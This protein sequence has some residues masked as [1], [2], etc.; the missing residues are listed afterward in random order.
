MRRGGSFEGSPERNQ[1]GVVQ[2][3]GWEALSEG[4]CC[5]CGTSDVLG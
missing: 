4:T 5:F 1:K 2:V 3:E